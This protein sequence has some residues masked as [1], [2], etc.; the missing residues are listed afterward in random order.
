MAMLNGQFLPKDNG[1]QRR[2]DIILIGEK[3]SEYFVK[4]PEKLYLGNYNVTPTDMLFQKYIRKYL[5]QVYITDMVKT[6]GKAGVDF[7]PEWNA[8]PAHKKYLEA[9]LQRIRPK[10]IGALGRKVERLLKEEFGSQ[11][12]IVYL[13]HPAAAARYPK[14]RAKWDNQFKELARQ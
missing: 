4:H 5:G 14:Q 11:Y 3:P 9:E 12:K 7:E 1:Q 8:D 10:T 6:E 2:T 13:I